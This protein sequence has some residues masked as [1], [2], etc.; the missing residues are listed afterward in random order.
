MCPVPFSHEESIELEWSDVKDAQL[1]ETFHCKA[2]EEC[3]TGVYGGISWPGKYPGYA[4]VVATKTVKTL[5]GDRTEVCLLDEVESRDTWQL[6]ERCGGLDLE[7][8]PSAWFG[9]DENP[10]ANDFMR[11]NSNRHKWYVVRSDILA[12]DK[13][14]QRILQ[15]IRHMLREDR[16]ALFL[17][18]GRVVDYLSQVEADKECELELGEFPAIEALGFA[19]L[20]GKRR[21]GRRSMTLEQIHQLQRECGMR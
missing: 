14:Y 11:S 17:K 16:K 5:G 7:Y 1:G 12:L 9:D 8:N 18:G 6:I 13:L 15:N 19:V 2:L 21:G 3:C 4:V 10:T 20:E